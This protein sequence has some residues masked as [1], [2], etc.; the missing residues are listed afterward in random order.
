MNLIRLKIIR[1]GRRRESSKIK[2]LWIPA[3]AG[4]TELWTVWYL[5]ICALIV[6]QKYNY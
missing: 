1:L 3:F 4:M 5:R 6:Y 2:G